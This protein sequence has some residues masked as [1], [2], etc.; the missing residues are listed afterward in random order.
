MT[1][2]IFHHVHFG[3]LSSSAFLQAVGSPD[4]IYDLHSPTHSPR[5][6]HLFPGGVDH[7]NEVLQVLEEKERETLG[8]GRGARWE[9]SWQRRDPLTL[10]V[11]GKEACP[12]EG[13][14][15][16][17]GLISLDKRRWK[18]G[19]QDRRAGRML[20][21]NPLFPPR[22]QAAS[23]TFSFSLFSNT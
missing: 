19:R 4:M 10:P 11:E 5:P 17:T 22:H 20:E 12:K 6:A 13:H 15:R 1:S 18:G 21:F 7:L 9:R 8:W 23:V 16:L 2:L 14:I 3:L